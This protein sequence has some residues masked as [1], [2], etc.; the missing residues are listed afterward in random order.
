MT[1]CRRLSLERS[2]KATARCE[3]GPGLRLLFEFL[4]RRPKV[5]KELARGRKD[6]EKDIFP[7]QA[8]VAFLTPARIWT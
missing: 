3:A 5:Q 2:G 6:E 7:S 4:K 1:A 8:V